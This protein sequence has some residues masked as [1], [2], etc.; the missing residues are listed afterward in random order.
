MMPEWNF[1]VTKRIA[2]CANSKNLPDFKKNLKTLDDND[3]MCIVEAVDNILSGTVN[4]SPVI[5]RQ[6]RPHAQELRRLSAIRITKKA[7]S[8]LSQI[9]GAILPALLPV[10]LS[11]VSS[12]VS[13]ALQ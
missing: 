1:N 13:H 10:I 2:A 6:L 8:Q 9:G 12:L 5:K 3:V 7:R 11:V 4:V